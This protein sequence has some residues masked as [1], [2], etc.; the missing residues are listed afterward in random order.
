M[1]SNRAA[2]KARRSWPRCKASSK[3]KLQREQDSGAGRGAHQAAL[4]HLAEAAAAAHLG[5]SDLRHAG[6]A[7]HHAI[8]NRLLRRARHHSQPVAAGAGA[9]QGLH[10]HPAQQF[11]QVAAHHRHLRKGPRLRG[12]DPHR[13][14]AQ[15]GRGRHRRALEVQ[16]RPGLGARRAAAGVAAAGGRVAARHQELRTSFWRR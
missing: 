1:P 9:H 5:R 16:G 2:K 6:A 3:Q 8:G 15:D 14:D 4:Q 7:H 13:R 12:A 10:R 11:L